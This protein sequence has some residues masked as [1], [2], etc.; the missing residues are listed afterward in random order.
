MKKV[1]LVI[2]II[3]IFLLVACGDSKYDEA[4]NQVIQLE[5][6]NL[7]RPGVEKQFDELKRENT[8][9]AVYEDGEFIKITYEIRSEDNSTWIYEKD[10]KGK[11]TRYGDKEDIEKMEPDYTEN[12][13]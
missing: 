4:I 8:K 9:I 7:D 1:V 11:Y 3:S 13:E 5:N 12:I 10:D 6:E 2:G